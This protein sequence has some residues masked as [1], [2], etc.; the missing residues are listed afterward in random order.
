MTHTPRPQLAALTSAR[1]FAAFHV[2]LF[3]MGVMK[4]LSHAPACLQKFA[5]VGY[6]AITFFFVLSGF[7]LVY[8]YTGR[9]FSLR[10]FWKAR[11]A[12]LYPV[13]L[14]SLLLAAPFFFYAVLK[15]NVPELAWF[16]THLASALVLV[17]T[18]LQAW[19]P[20]AAL[21]WN[22]VA[23]A[24]SVEIFF[25]MLFPVLLARFSRIS[26]QG[27][28]A[29]G[30][31]CWMLA[32]ATALA[33]V[34]LSPDHIVADASYND[35]SW[36]NAL[37]FNPLVR[38]PEFVVGMACGYWLVREDPNPKLATPLV[39]GGT[40][41]AL[42][43]TAFSHL[44]PY[45]V[46]H[47]G[48]YA[49]AFAAIICGLALRPR[50]TSFLEFRW[51]LLLGESSYAFYLLHVMALGMFLF[52]ITPQSPTPRDLNSFVPL[53]TPGRLIGAAVTTTV[54]AVLVFRFVEEPARKWLR[55]KPRPHA[56]PTPT[57][58]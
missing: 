57:S 13:Y 6:V 23:W 20:Q 4:G 15:I 5:G 8:T 53:A 52:P 36:L 22:G 27:L 37:K 11:L 3:H 18:M 54:V 33:Y 46:M 38:L 2:F 19:V 24:V 14:L 9:D 51:L 32:L 42:V 17:L 50:W 41:V 10:Q 31:A 16:K 25:Y 49:P 39:L 26:N 40:A 7:I 35:R 30:L 45:P 21:G 58:A 29:I 34:V 56:A 1:F 44:I 28:A 47:T 48:L 43:T 55:G 12:R